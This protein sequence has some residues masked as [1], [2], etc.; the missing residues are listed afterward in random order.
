MSDQIDSSTFYSEEIE[1]LI[2]Y[3]TY[4]QSNQIYKK[5]FDLDNRITSEGYISKSNNRVGKWS[6]YDKS[7]Y[8][9]EVHEYF[10]IEE[11]EY[12]NQSWAFDKS[13][14]TLFSKSKFVEFL[15]NKDTIPLNEPLRAAV[16]LR[17]NLFEYEDSGFYVLLS[18]GYE[19]NLE[20]KFAN[21]K[22]I[23]LDTFYSLA[24]DSLN[25]GVF[26]SEIDSKYLVPFGKWFKTNGDKTLRGIAI[27]YH[28]EKLKDKDS[29]YIEV[30]KTYFEKKLHVKDSVVH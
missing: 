5:N 9:K 29:F 6:L 8:L 7:S 18:K 14:D 19:N 28:K 23:E 25:A 13:G 26:D 30:N 16:Y 21:E 24:I 15:F 17:A 2:V 27:E 10:E 22:K 12:L 3:K 11:D 1:N 20:E 4:Y